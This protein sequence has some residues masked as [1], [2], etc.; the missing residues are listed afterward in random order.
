[1]M[2]I[3][4]LAHYRKHQVFE[5]LERYVHF[6][7][8]FATAVATF[9]TIGTNQYIFNID[10]YLYSSI[11][12][13]LESIRNI[14]W[15]GKISDAYTLL[16]KYYD[17]AIVNV[18]INL[19]LRDHCSIENFVVDK[20]NDWLKNNRKLPEYKEMVRYI[21]KHAELAPINR[22]FEQ[23]N[24]YQAIRDRCNDHTHYNCFD[25]I[26]LN[27]SEVFVQNRSLTLDRLGVDLTDL[28]ILHLSYIFFLNAHYMSS[29]DYVDHLE[30]GMTP[31]SD[32]EY[33]VAP[34]V[35][36][37]FDEILKKHRPDLADLIKA[38]TSMHLA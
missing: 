1:M 17:S 4:E 27:I 38:N 30:C 28:F 15:N 26:L 8:T 32:S 18:Y 5:E 23:D 22:L 20:V 10:S 2:K 25:N 34:F 12:G 19:Y 31:P 37:T 3:D 7:E 9:V 21:K 33:W 24:R 6:Y 13:T 14:L 36:E 16:R 11:Q 35:Q 29:S